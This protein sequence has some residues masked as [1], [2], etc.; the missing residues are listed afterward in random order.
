MNVTRMNEIKLR[1]KN[2]GLNLFNIFKES[3]ANGLD[4]IGEEAFEEAIEIGIENTITSLLYAAIDNKKMISLL[5][6]VWNIPYKEAEKRI[7]F[8]KHK[9]ALRNIHD[10]LKNNG[11]SEKEIKEIFKEKNISIRLRRE[12]HLLN[13]WNKPKKILDNLD[14]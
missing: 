9:E 6:Q 4:K 3:Y 5:N 12:N 7:D 11:K 10:H 2:G 14:D 1:I 8:V 13:F